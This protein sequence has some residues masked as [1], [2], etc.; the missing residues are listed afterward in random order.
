MAFSM[1]VDNVVESSLSGVVLIGLSSEIPTINNL[2]LSKVLITSPGARP[3]EAQILEVQ[4]ISEAWSRDVKV[5]IR[6]DA[7]KHEIVR[8]AVITSL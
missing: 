1:V 7:L 5:G 3:I 2:L 4:P 8:G 6:V